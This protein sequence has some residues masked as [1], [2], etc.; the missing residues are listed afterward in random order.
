MNSL[1]RI[2]LRTLLLV[3]AISLSS[4]ALSSCMLWDVV[5]PSAGIDVSSEI[6]A[7]DKEQN[8]AAD[9]EIGGT[10]NTADTISIQNT[11]EGPNFWFMLLFA[12]GWLLPGPGAIWRGLLN[13]F[14]RKE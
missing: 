10:S 5:K 1:L 14:G 2:N 7:G 12:M 4:G 6:V 11:D 8:Y 13:L 3:M 9:V